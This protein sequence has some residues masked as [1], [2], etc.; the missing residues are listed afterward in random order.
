LASVWGVAGG[1]GQ[2]ADGSQTSSAWLVSARR[3]GLAV[4]DVIKGAYE[5]VPFWVR[6]ALPLGAPVPASAL[7]PHP[8]ATVVVDEAAAAGLK[9]ANYFRATYA[10]KPAWQGL[11]NPDARTRPPR[12]PGAHAG[13]RSARGDGAGGRRRLVRV[14]SRSGAGPTFARA[15]TSGHRG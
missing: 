5:G 14:A 3:S 10:S 6:P 8:H 2:A 1:D 7:Q 9:L 15:L 13:A 4:W 12:A 11:W